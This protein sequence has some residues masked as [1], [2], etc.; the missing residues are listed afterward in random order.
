MNDGMFIDCNQAFFDMSSYKREEVIGRTS[1][2]VGIWADARD[3]QAM[4]NMLRQDSSICGLEVQLRRKGGVI[5]WGQIS[6]SVIEIDGVRCAL[7]ITR[8]ISAARTAENTIRSLAFYDPLTGLPNRRMLMERLRQPQDAGAMG[9]RSQAL[10]MIDLDHFKTLN[11]TLGHPCGDLMLKEVAR[12]IVACA[13]EADTVCRMGGDEFVVLLE[14][15]SKVAEE[16]AAQAKAVG[17]K[18]L[19]ALDQPCLLDYHD[20]T[21]RP[22]SESPSSGI[23]KTTRMSSCSRLKL[24]CIRP[25]RRV[26]I[27]CAFSP[28]RCRLP[29]TPALR[30]RRICDRGSRQNNSCFTISRRW[31]GA[32]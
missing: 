29:S 26:A 6:A 24:P 21:P 19:A 9:D 16:A 5:G 3:R 30:W 8:D 28:P 18:I 13:H 10:L 12:R 25:R 1:E 7:S 20:I 4:M 15:L 27:P 22:A 14:E 32:M 11:D 31:S 23:G 17:E 2:E